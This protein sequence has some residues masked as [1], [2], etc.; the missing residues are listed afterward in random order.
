MN[1]TWNA[2]LIIGVILISLAAIA[3]IS[4]L[5][6]LGI[7]TYKDAKSRGLNAPLWTLI[8]ILASRSPVLGLLIYILIGR[9]ESKITCPECTEKTSSKAVYCDHCGKTIDRSRV[10]PSPSA[11][12]WLVAML[13]A[14]L[15]FIIGFGGGIAVITLNDANPGLFPNTSIGKVETGFGDKWKLTYYASTETMNKTIYINENGPKSLYFKGAC[16]EG[17]MML[18]VIMGDEIQTFDVSGQTEESMIDLSQYDTRSVTLQLINSDV[19][20]GEFEANWK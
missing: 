11:K 20:N 12:K 4:I 6:F 7:W 8:V 2:P 16:E 17:T 10:V 18:V 19:E 1:T 15:V 13:A 9:R 5:V 3:L 14:F